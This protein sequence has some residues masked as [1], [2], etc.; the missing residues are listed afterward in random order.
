MISRSERW[1]D[2]PGYEGRYQ[3]STRGHVRALDRIDD[4][5]L[6][7]TARQRRCQVL[8]NGRCYVVLC[9]KGVSRLHCVSVLLARA[10]AIPNPHGGRYIIHR[11]RDNGNFQRSN[12]AWATLAEQRM[13]EGRKFSCP[14]YGVT[15]VK[16]GL[17]GR[18]RWVAVLRQNRCRYDLGYFATP[19]EA[20]YAYDR[21]VKRRR[22]A[23]PLNGLKKPAAP[24]LAVRSLPG[25]IWRSFPGARSK[26]QISNKGRVRTVAHRT[27]RG[28]RVLPRLRK[29][30]VT[31]TGARTIL[32]K[33]RRFGIAKAL[34][35]AFPGRAISSGAR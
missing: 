4:G 21:E 24:D 35:R 30:F 20:A 22:L 31:P 19:E 16:R 3:V 6:H 11:N 17:S 12:L 7:R 13:H 9:K 15:H 2:V 10:Y 27:R 18:L 29:I 25:E 8:A 14:Y 23:R 34:A 26:Y 1:Y 28:R 5:G 32:L 33:Q